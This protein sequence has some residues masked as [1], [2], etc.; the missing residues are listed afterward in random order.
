MRKFFV[1]YTLI[2]AVG[3]V[4][5]RYYIELEDNMNGMTPI[6]VIPSSSVQGNSLPSKITI[7]RKESFVWRRENVS[8]D[9]ECCRNCDC[10]RIKI[11][12][13]VLLFLNCA[14]K[15]CFF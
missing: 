3:N 10:F 15:L 8:C 1:L 4:L 2:T 14:N 11:A 6:Y 5:V 7:L 13:K 9:Y 12:A